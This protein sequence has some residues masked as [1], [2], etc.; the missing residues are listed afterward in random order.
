MPFPRKLIRKKKD[1]TDNAGGKGL[2][3]FPFPKQH[4]AVSIRTV[5]CCKSNKSSSVLS[6]SSSTPV[7]SSSSPSFPKI[8]RR[9]IDKLSDRDDPQTHFPRSSLHFTLCQLAR[10]ARRLCFSLSTERVCARE[11]PLSNQIPHLID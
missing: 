1:T 4:L 2:R 5:A 10:L 9:G 11:C 7:T 8:P 3:G 6:S